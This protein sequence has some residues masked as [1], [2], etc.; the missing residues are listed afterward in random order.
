MFDQQQQD[1]VLNILDVQALKML[2]VM[3][4]ALIGLQFM[5]RIY[6]GPNE[7]CGSVLLAFHVGMDQYLLIPFLVGWTSIYQLFWCSPGVQGFDTLQCLF[8]VL[9]FLV[10][11]VAPFEILQD[12]VMGKLAVWKRTLVLLANCSSRYRSRCCWFN[13]AQGSRC[14]MQLDTRP[15]MIKYV[16]MLV[17]PHWRNDKVKN[18]RMWKF[19]RIDTWPL[20]TQPD[21]NG[22]MMMMTGPQVEGG[23]RSSDVDGMM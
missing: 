13:E 18:R 15:N 12:V 2:K 22:L 7:D 17:L 9:S 5:E 23:M 8:S 19:A 10:A 6:I 21:R 3:Y 14:E 11:Y 16:Q 4:V 1:N 20:W